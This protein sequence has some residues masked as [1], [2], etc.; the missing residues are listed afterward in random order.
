MNTYFCLHGRRG[1]MLWLC[2]PGLLLLEV[3]GLLPAH[4]AAQVQ[5]AGEYSAP[6]PPTPTPTFTATPTLTPT[7][8]FTPTATPTA[9]PTS[10]PCLF[11][12][13]YTVDANDAKNF[14]FLN[15]D[16]GFGTLPQCLR[17]TIEDCKNEAL[18]A[19]RLRIFCA[20][21]SGHSDCRHNSCVEE[22]DG[23]HCKAHQYRNC[24]RRKLGVPKVKGQLYATFLIDSNCQYQGQRAVGEAL[25]DEDRLWNYKSAGHTLSGRV[26]GAVEY[27]G[28]ASPI[29]LLLD[30]TVDLDAEQSI[31]S[32]PVNPAAGGSF[33]TWKA[34][35]PLIPMKMA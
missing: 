6:P 24:V 3:V 27:L 17:D 34:S 29:S 7:L 33:F 19:N 12:Y 32:F 1:L 30:D 22:P 31:V 2:V 15:P 18:D 23:P 16:R 8:T 35:S 26:C 14:A 11:A 21:N 28:R 25:P 4:T 20:Q 9:S 5:N 13:R 10:V